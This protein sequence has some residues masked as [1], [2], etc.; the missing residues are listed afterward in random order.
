MK[1]LS[2]ILAATLFVF[3]VKAELVGKLENFKVD[4]VDNKEIYSDAND[5]KNGDIIE[6]VITYQNKF[7]YEITNVSIDG[8]IPEETDFVSFQK[9]KFEPYFR[10]G[11]NKVWSKEPIV[12]KIV[13]GKIKES[14][15]KYSDYTGLKWDV[16]KMQPNEEVVF[17]YRVKVKEN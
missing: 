6:Y 11:E 13:N 1:K 14:K 16:L 9:S 17:K 10:V 4:L 5:A 3:N 7:N 8:L 12:R 15:A 2:I